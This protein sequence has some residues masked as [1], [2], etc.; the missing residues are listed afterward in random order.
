MSE[1]GLKIGAWV[2]VAGICA[3]CYWVEELF[4]LQLRLER[5]RMWFKVLCINLR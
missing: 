5:T 4:M 1:E 3:L 2:S